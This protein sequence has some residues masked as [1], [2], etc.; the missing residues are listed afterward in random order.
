VVDVQ[1]RAMTQALPTELGQAVVVEPRPGGN[2]NIAAEAV[3]R[4]AADGYTLLVSAPFLINNPL[5][6][7]GLRWAPRDL[8]PLARFSLSPS[9]MCVPAALPVRTVR[10]YVELARRSKPA[11]QFGDPGAGTTQTMAVEILKSVAG[12]ELEAVSYKGAPP[13]ALDL[14]NNTFS[15]SVLPSSVAIPHV[16]S[17][18]LRALATTSATRSVQ[19]PDVPTMAEAGFADVTV[20]SWYGLHAP[21]QTPS[22]VMRKLEAAIRAAMSRPE[23]PQR[24]IASGGEAAF[25]GTDE[26]ARFL[27]QEV[28]LWDRIHRSLRK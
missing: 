6:E 21:A 27:Q 14:I 2:G 16:K 5:Q 23:T 8:S 13:V 9:F 26:F 18:K 20:V 1:T 12:I 25:M 10:E 24:M 19:L 22:S 11:L 15:M 17:G 7:Q 3:A 28:Q 4:A